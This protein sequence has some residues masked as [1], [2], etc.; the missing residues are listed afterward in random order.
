MHLAAC[1]PNVIRVKEVLQ[2]LL[3]ANNLLTCGNRQPQRLWPGST[4]SQRRI[5]TRRVF[6]SLSAKCACTTKSP[7]RLE[8]ALC[9][10]CHPLSIT[11]MWKKRVKRGAV[12]DTDEVPANPS[13]MMQDTAE[14]SDSGDEESTDDGSSG[15]VD[16]DVEAIAGLPQ[17]DSPRRNRE[18][19][20]P[21]GNL[22]P[23]MATNIHHCYAC[24]QRLW[25]LPRWLGFGKTRGLRWWRCRR[26]GLE[27]RDV[28]MSL[29]REFT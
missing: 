23:V 5:Y 1:C 11:E 2:Y 16:P 29:R 17:D 27:A 6:R 8:H 18:D 3:R 14:S 10:D 20:D 24:H 12:A 26:C 28:L 25:I 15:G 4:I 9:R 13:V 7:P 21:R 22:K 19:F